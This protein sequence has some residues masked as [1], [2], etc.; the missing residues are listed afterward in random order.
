M[1]E[2]K[3]SDELEERCNKPFAIVNCQ[4]K[5]GHGGD[6]SIYYDRDA[7][8]FEGWE[9]PYRKDCPC[10]CHRTEGMMHIDAC[11]KPDPPGRA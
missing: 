4:R 7:P 10:P 9:L 1:D 6:C 2:V 3:T 11:C 8:V 5:K